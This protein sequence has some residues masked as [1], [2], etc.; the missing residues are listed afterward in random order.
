MKYD[1]KQ[2]L[3]M[4]YH[5]VDA[6]ELENPKQ[7]LPPVQERIDK[8]KRLLDRE[9]RGGKK[10]PDDRLKHYKAQLEVYNTLLHP[11]QNKKR[12]LWKSIWGG[13]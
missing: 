10:I 11:D 4:A 13:K 7:E 6:D 2:R 12:S 8:L 3:N 1:M 5:G 9:E